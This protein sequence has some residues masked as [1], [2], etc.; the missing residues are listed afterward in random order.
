[1]A[2]IRIASGKVIDACPACRFIAKELGINLVS[3]P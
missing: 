1:M 3:K 2:A